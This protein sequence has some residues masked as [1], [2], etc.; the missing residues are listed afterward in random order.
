MATGAGC[1]PCECDVGGSYD[2]LCDLASG[3]CRCRPGIEGRKCDRVIP[4]Y[5]FAL[6]DNLKYEAEKARGI[7]VSIRG[8]EP[9]NNSYMGLNVLILVH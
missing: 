8:I 9:G 1:K 3:Q 2:N 6:S 4:G 7:G 5:Y